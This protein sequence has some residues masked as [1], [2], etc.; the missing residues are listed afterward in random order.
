MNIHAD[1]AYHALANVEL[2]L[3]GL[4]NRLKGNGGEKAA[5]YIERAFEWLAKAKDEIGEIDEYPKT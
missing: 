3:L 5:D 1:E 2:I 4:Q